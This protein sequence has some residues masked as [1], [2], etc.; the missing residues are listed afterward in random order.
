MDES[1]PVALCFSSTMTRAPASEAST[2]ALM[3]AMPLP[4]TTMSASLFSWDL[5]G[6]SATA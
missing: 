1:P 4:M 2:A 3:P 5:A 6:V